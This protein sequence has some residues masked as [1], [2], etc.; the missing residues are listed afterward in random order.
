MEFKMNYFIV[1]RIY[2]LNTNGLSNKIFE[3]LVVN[4]ITI[5]MLIPSKKNLCLNFNYTFSLLYL[6]THKVLR[7][8]KYYAPTCTH[9]A[10]IFLLRAHAHT[11]STN[12]A[13]QQLS[14]RHTAP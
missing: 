12:K 3:P 5:F 1:F 2:R 4:F 11:Y 14:S 6:F 7:T 10:Y 9:T 13:G 8:L